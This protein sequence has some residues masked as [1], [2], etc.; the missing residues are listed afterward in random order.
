MKRE[1]ERLAKS[2]AD[3][4]RGVVSRGRVARV[5]PAADGVPQA[6]QIA[7]G[8]SVH[9]RVA[10]LQPYGLAA[11]P[12]PGAEALLLWPG[13]ARERGYAVTVDD[14]RDRPQLKPGEVAIFNRVTGAK[15]LLRADGVIELDG[16]TRVA[17]DLEVDGNVTAAGDVTDAA[18]SM[19]ADRLVFNAH[20]HP[21]SDGPTGPTSTPMGGGA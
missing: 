6:V 21:T 1:L 3:R 2:L 14:R 4:I 8:R 20:V 18:A 9:D 10:H 7:I 5:D 13:G 19:A 11:V 12:L 17:G 15:V 16:P